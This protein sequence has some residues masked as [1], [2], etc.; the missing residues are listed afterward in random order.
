MPA[1][2][3]CSYGVEVSVGLPVAGEV[4]ALAVDEDAAAGLVDVG[5]AAHEPRVRGDLRLAAP[6][7]DDDLDAG[8]VARLKRLGLGQREVAVGVAEEPAARPEQGAVEVG[9]DA[10]E[11]HGARKLRHVSANSV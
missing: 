11:C 4:G 10:A 1:S 8:A 7:H 5:G 2:T 3:I 9:V 6:G